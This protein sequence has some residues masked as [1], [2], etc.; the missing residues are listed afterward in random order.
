MRSCRATGIKEL[1]HCEC[2]LLL[3]LFRSSPKK[4]ICPETSGRSDRVGHQNS[5]R[6][7]ARELRVCLQYD[8]DKRLSWTTERITTRE[9]DAAHSLLDFLTFICRCFTVKDKRRLSCFEGGS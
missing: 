6:H 5:S 8:V 9:E 1:G 4:A 3:I 7:I 2:F